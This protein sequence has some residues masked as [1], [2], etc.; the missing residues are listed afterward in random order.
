[1]PDL[2]YLALRL[3]FRECA[4]FIRLGRNPRFGSECLSV[5][6]STVSKYKIRAETPL[7]DHA[8]ELLTFLSRDQVAAKVAAP[9]GVYL[10]L[11]RRTIIGL[12]FEGPDPALTDDGRRQQA[13]LERVHRRE[14]YFNPAGVWS[15]NFLPASMRPMF[16]QVI[17][18][19]GARRVAPAVVVDDVPEPRL[20]ADVPMLPL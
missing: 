8:G 20:P 15:L 12:R 13:G 17:V 1:M 16:E 19:C 11:R 18:D 5:R 9:A 3:K 4:C 2:A 6:K 14:T 10:I 7:Y